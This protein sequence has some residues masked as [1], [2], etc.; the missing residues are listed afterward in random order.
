M[1]V[2]T[3]WTEEGEPQLGGC[4]DVQRFGKGGGSRGV[5]ES[6]KVRSVKMD[7]DRNCLLPWFSTANKKE[8]NDMKKL[9]KL[10]ALLLAVAMVLSMAA[11]CNK[12]EPAPTEPSDEVAT[13]P[14][15][16]L[17][18]QVLATSDLHGKFVPYDYALNAES[19]GGSAAQIATFISEV[20]TD[21]T[22][23]IDCGDTVQGNSAEL[24]FEDDIHPMIQGLN[25]MNYDVWVAGNHEFNYGVDTLRSLAADFEGD[26]LCGNVYDAEGATLGAN[27]V[28]KE[29]EGVK[30]AIIGMVTPNI[31]R[32]DAQNLKDY[33]VTD[34][35]EET[36]K[37]ID[38][39]KDDV[40]I[41]IAAEHMGENNEY[42][43]PNSGAYDL[44]DACPEI[45]VIIAAHDHKQ[46]A[47]IERNGVKIVENANEGKSVAQI[48]FTVEKT[49]D[50]AA[51][52]ACEAVSVSMEEYA[53]EQSIVDATVD[54]DAKAKANAEVVI[55]QLVNG[56]LAPADEIT[57]IPQARLEPTAL[58]N[59]INE[60]QMYY[61]D[62]KV[63]A[64]ALFIDDANLQ[65]G[66]I[67]N[68]DM[69]LVYK[70]TNTLYKM[71][72]TGAQLK[73]YMEW[74]AS[75]YNQYQDGD[76]TISFNP[77]ARGYNYDMFYG[78]NYKVNI[79]K[80]V[81]ERIEDLTWADGTPV[82][83]DDVF[84]LA[85][86]NYR[87]SSQLTSYG[88]IFQEG[89]ELP[90]ILEIDVRGDIGGVR[91]IIAEYIKNVKGGVLDASVIG[92]ETSWEVIGNDWD[93]DL[94]QKAVDLL[95]SGK[96][97]IKNAEGNRQVN[98]ASITVEDLEG[99][100]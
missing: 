28:I 39:I 92:G 93:A 73:K 16:T 44:A 76:L 58:I 15:E 79:A 64:S 65:S 3:A 52:K 66:D 75:Y 33:T 95:N 12:V 21:N 77:D 5:R 56:P 53:A 9:T 49:E 40:D 22:V 61:T 70:Y 19:A 20:K 85:V 48:K 24:F 35:V 10:W 74:S 26:F 62:A 37:V 25:L 78:V 63:S 8:S 36:R 83:D 30:V 32:W 51:V 72:M 97:E 13:T 88:P 18:I 7:Q 68:C 98:I 14:V 11:G 45:D 59:L 81:G 99:V 31:V 84:I 1:P 50:G 23:V 46:F 89:D 80:P 2:K 57:G 43:V 41:I 29:I 47:D 54:A 100:E 86:N 67:R 6:Q 96:L 55:G 34:P 60:V 82:A 17:E 42:G 87:A 90:T 91:E 69:A 4:P 71:E 27:Y 94:H 38:E